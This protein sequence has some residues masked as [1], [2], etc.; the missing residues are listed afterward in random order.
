MIKLDERGHQCPLPVINT[1]KAIENAPGGETVLVLTDNEISVQNLNKLAVQKGYGFSFV[2]KA[3]NLFESTITVSEGS[4]PTGETAEEP[5]YVECTPF[6]TVA[7]VSS[8]TMGSGDD[9]LGRLLM[10]SFIFALTQTS[11]LPAEMVFYNGG[12]FLT[13]EGSPALEDLKS[14]QEAGVKIHTCGTCL[15]HYNLNDK[16]VIGD[17]SNMYE[18]VEILN[19]A[20][21][22]IR[23]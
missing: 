14:L 3:D 16:L 20:S 22:I 21:K 17:V 13:C 8:S 1:K 7:A 2:K 9:D 15:N 10:K 6:K 4:A 5:V 11:P 23:P 18:I 12:A 19:G